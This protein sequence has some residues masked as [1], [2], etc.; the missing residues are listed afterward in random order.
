MK[1]RCII[2]FLLFFGAEVY[3]QTTA[4]L[5]RLELKGP[6]N[7]VVEEFYN[8]YEKEGKDWE[9]EPDR[10]RETT[11]NRSGLYLSQSGTRKGKPQGKLTFEY[12]N[13]SRLLAK[14]QIDENEKLVRKNTFRFDSDGNM[15]EEVEFDKNSKVK[16]RTTYYYDDSGRVIREVRGGGDGSTWFTFEHIYDE[17]GNMVEEISKTAE[18]KVD[19]KTVF[20]YNER[21]QEIENQHFDASGKMVD[22][23]KNEIDQN[24]NILKKQHIDPKGTVYEEMHYSYN[25]E[26]RLTLELRNPTDDGF[27]NRKN[28]TYDEQGN[29]IKETFESGDGKYSDLMTYEFEYDEMGNWIQKKFFRNSEEVEL[30]KRTIQYFE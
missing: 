10:T 2:I 18:G 24:G 8:N 12:D 22:Q 17:K 27:Q 11:F 25:G 5:D 16:K 19:W 23:W 21:N 20:I 4:D 30:V 15:V 26:N 29:V 9:E 13:N 7:R 28:F 1:F 3:A 14:S 6:V